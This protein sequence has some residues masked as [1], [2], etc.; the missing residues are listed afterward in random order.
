MSFSK[1]A[2]EIINTIKTDYGDYQI[3]THKKQDQKTVSPT[4]PCKHSCS[5]TEL[6][7]TPICHNKKTTRDT[8]K[9]ENPILID[10]RGGAKSMSANRMLTDRTSSKSKKI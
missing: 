10:K 3:S 2:A 6:V 9:K 5:A 1:K 7:I 8:L 4:F